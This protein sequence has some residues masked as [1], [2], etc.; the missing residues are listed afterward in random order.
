MITPVPYPNSKLKGILQQIILWGFFL[1]T[2]SHS[3]Q[4][5]KYTE[6]QVKAVYLFNFAGFIRWPESA[7]S[8]TPATFQYC[9]LSEDNDV[10]NILKKVIAKET[11]K[12]RKLVFRLISN[13]NDLKYCQVVYFQASELSQFSGLRANLNG[14]SVLTVSDAN[15]FAEQGGMLGFSHLGK[16]LRSVINIRR[17]EQAKLKA[18]AKLLRLAIIV[19]GK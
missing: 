10:I 6:D 7:F 12:G 15:G 13:Q 16:R 5:A 2:I 17:L 19:N 1:F 4:A 8:E 3:S 14:K 18:S 11:V 9:A